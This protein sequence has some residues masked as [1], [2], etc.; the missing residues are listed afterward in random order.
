MII[1]RAKFEDLCGDLL[2]QGMA[3]VEQVLK[4]GK[5][6]KSQIDEIVLVGGSTR[7]P[8]VQQLLSEYFNGKEL[9]KS[10][11]PDEAVA[12]GSAIQAAILAGHGDSRTNELLLLDICPLSLGV[13][14][15]G[16]VNTIL[17]PRGTTIPCK[18]T[19]TFSNYADNL[20]TSCP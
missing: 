13:E 12:Y 1:T 11:N 2:N 8:K 5:T 20:E 18:K 9:C 3:P 19:Q 16:S 4:Q 10:V 17:I 15:A 7:V 6:S 14:T